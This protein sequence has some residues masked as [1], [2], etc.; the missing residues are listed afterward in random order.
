MKW[1]VSKGDG[2][3][4]KEEREFNLLIEPVKTTTQNNCV[5]VRIVCLFWN[6]I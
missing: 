4:Y 1:D 5:E 6:E 2:T 3:D